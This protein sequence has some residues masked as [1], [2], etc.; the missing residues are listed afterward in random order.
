MSAGTQTA[1]KAAVYRPSVRLRENMPASHLSTKP[2]I[3]YIMLNHDHLLSTTHKVSTHI[4]KIK[5]IR[6]FLEIINFFAAV[7]DLRN[8]YTL[9]CT[10]LRTLYHGVRTCIR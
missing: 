7:F 3:M 1:Q 5:K 4:M 10:Q 9:K 8:I 6:Y 2:R